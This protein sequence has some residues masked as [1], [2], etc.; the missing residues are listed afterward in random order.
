MPKPV[1]GYVRVSTEEQSREGISLHAQR[2]RIEAYCGMRGFT[3]GDVLVDAGVSAS[4]ALRTRPAGADLLA[5]IRKRDVSGVI[6]FKLD[7]LFRNCVDCLTNAEAWDKAGI[8][9]HLLDLG[10]QAVDT[11]SAIGK[12]FLTVMAGAAELER[13]QISERTSSVLRHKASKGEYTGGQAP[14][15][16]RLA[17]DGTRLLEDSRE[18]QVLARVRALRSQKC[19]LRMIAATLNREGLMSRTGRTF[20]LVQL[21]RMLSV[22]AG[23]RAVL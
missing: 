16:Q 13:N 9:L 1:L 8:A 4:K 22:G 15:G 14:Y 12:F 11:S 5:R 18:Q 2:A 6:A 10:G 19:S 23:A 3:L 20:S 7:R 21:T 17:P